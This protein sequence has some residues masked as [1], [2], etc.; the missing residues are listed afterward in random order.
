[1]SRLPP[2][3][4]SEGEGSSGFAEAPAPKIAASTQ[5]A[6]P[7]RNTGGAPT[8]MAMTACL[9]RNHGVQGGR[10]TCCNGLAEARLTHCIAY[11]DLPGHGTRP[12]CLSG[13]T[14]PALASVASTAAPRSAT[15]LPLRQARFGFKVSVAGRR[16]QRG[17]GL[18][19][20]AVTTSAAAVGATWVRLR[21]LGCSKWS[22]AQPLT[23]PRSL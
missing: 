23:R 9:G 17:L 12:N 11:A 5:A 22:A 19:H 6:D 15:L 2:S 4:I 3:G 18:S 16:L 8:M 10:S 1:M 20:P 13:P 14:G 21:G 7:L